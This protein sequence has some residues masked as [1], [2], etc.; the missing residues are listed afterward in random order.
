ME[1]FIVLDYLAR[2]PEALAQQRA[3][4]VDGRLRHRE[5]VVA[6]L[7]DAPEAL[8]RVLRGDHFGKAIIAV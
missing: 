1:G 7:D 5:D 3:W 4:E 8:R 6:G 2:Y